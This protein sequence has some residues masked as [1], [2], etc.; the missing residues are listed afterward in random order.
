[1]ACYAKAWKA[2]AKWWVPICLIAGGLM[3]FELGPKQLSKA[4]SAAIIQTL[5]ELA[6][7]LGQ[8]DGLRMEAL[9]GELFE[10][11][12][13]YAKTVATFTL[14]AIPIVAILTIVLLCSS[15]M[16]VKDRR[17]RY[18]P[19]RI[20]FVALVNTLMAF[21]KILVLFLFFPL[22]V[23]LYIKLY[24]VSLAMVDEQQNLTE[25]I[26]QSWHLSSGHFWPLLGMVALNSILQFAMVPTVIGLIP[27]SGFTTT[28]R[29]AAYAMLRHL[30]QRV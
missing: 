23:Y 2:F 9:T 26:Q 14:Y 19:W 10:S 16:A 1:M 28:T 4:E 29:T 15:I 27:A 24:F 7:A 12:M 18:S 20:L 8:E 6:A 22:G 5:S 30:T 21:A 13:D 11:V 17:I 25:A 3:V